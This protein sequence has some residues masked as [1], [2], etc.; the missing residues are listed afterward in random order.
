[1]GWSFDQ[2]GGGAVYW[3]NSGVV[4]KPDNPEREPIGDAL[5][6]L[7]ASPEFQYIR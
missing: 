2:Y 4:K 5:W 7:F 3:D 6:A 1:V